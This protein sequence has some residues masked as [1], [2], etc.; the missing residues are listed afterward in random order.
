MEK[1]GGGASAAVAILSMTIGG[2]TAGEAQLLV[3]LA[4]GSEAE[5]DTREQLLRLVAEHDVEDWLF[6]R[7]I[8]IDQTQIPHSHPVLTLHTRHLGDDLALLSTFIHEQF[9]WLED[10]ETLDAFR[11]AMGDFEG[12]FPEVPDSSNG[13][14]RD[15]ESTYRHLLVCDLE[16][17][18]MTRL[19]GETR[20]RETL[21]ATTHY[22][23]I[24][25]RV[26]DDPRIRQVSERHGFI[27]R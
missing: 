4:H 24:Y 27:L 14:A 23:W 25:E 7:E 22:E 10:G 5:Q 8:L 2:A 6:T 20:A 13:G 12:L 26:L 21:A 18:G 15:V 17:Q 19:V 16:L 9:H 11:A 1:R 3:R